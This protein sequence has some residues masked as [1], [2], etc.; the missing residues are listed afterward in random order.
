VNAGI[1]DLGTPLI[2][3]GIEIIHVP[4]GPATDTP[5]ISAA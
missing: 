3:L 4:E 1:G 5:S 2:K